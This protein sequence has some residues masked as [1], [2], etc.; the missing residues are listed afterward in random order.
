[1]ALLSAFGSSVAWPYSAHQFS[2]LFLVIG[3]SLL[4]VTPSSITKAKQLVFDNQE[5]KGYN[6]PVFRNIVA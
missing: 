4:W 5:K 1:M 6:C 2:M 3:T